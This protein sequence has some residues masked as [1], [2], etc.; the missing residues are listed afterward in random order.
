MV[1]WAW[2]DVTRLHR[3]RRGSDSMDASSARGGQRRAIVLAAG[4]GERLLRLTERLTGAPLPKQYCDLAGDDE[5]LLQSTLRRLGRHV[6]IDHTRVVID[7]RHR[8]RAIAQ[9][10][11]FPAA[12][13]FGQPSDC[14]TAVGTLVPLIDIL[15]DD[16]DA[17]VVISPSDHGVLDEA[18]L[19]DAM[20]HLFQVAEERR[21]IVVLGAEPDGMACDDGWLLPFAPMRPGLRGAVQPVARYVHPAGSEDTTGLVGA[22]AVHSTCVVVAPGAELLA[23]FERLTPRL[24]R[25]FLYGA[26]MPPAEGSA[27][28]DLAYDGLGS[29]DLARDILSLA[30]ELRMVVLPRQ[31]GWSDLGSEAR[32][33]AWLS[34]RRSGEMMPWPLAGGR[35]S[36]AGGYRR[37]HPA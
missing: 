21:A 16:P 34:K 31:A 12:D 25:L 17:I 9:L 13:V 35:C 3:Q 28:L 14:G 30:L 15:I 1:G 18:V 24:L 32:L 2:R 22:G 29:L 19:D 5:T 6:P 23:L 4:P 11:R 8:S 27:F 10:R 7:G 37:V 20:T 36:R 26:A 33:L